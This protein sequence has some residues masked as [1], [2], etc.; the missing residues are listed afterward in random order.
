MYP[1]TKHGGTPGKRGG[2]GG[3]AAKGK[4][5]TIDSLLSGKSD[6]TKKK[7]G[8]TKTVEVVPKSWTRD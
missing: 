6:K 7:S 2:K 8:P 1:H 5:P 4:E 3:K